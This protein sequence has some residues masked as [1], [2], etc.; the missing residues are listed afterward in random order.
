MILDKTFTRA[1]AERLH[2]GVR[3]ANCWSYMAPYFEEAMQGGVVTAQVKW[4]STPVG[5]PETFW[6]A[7]GEVRASMDMTSDGPPLLP[8]LWILESDL[9]RP[10]HG[11]P[12]ANGTGVDASFCFTAMHLRVEHDAATGKTQV[13]TV[14]VDEDRTQVM[15]DPVLSPFLRQDL[16]SEPG[17]TGIYTIVQVAF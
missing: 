5:G 9:N 10:V 16:F 2:R 14:K 12:L 15:D 11:S 17:H 1:H 6:W 7:Q 3:M 4:A 8:L 13:T